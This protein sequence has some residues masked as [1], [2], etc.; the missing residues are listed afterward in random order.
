MGHD[1]SG[2]RALGPLLAGGPAP[3]VYI[4]SGP[5]LLPAWF[6]RALAP[7]LGAGTGLWWIDACNDFDVHGLS[8]AARALGFDPRS[9]LRR[10][11]L[12]RAFNL[13]QLESIV[14]GKLPAVWNGEPVVLCDPSPMIGD[15]EIPDGDRRRVG[16]SII[17][18]MR[19]L[20]AVWLVLAV[21]RGAGRDWWFE[22]LSARA[23]A[24]VRLG[25]GGGGWEL[26]KA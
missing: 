18:G 20:P 8:R 4:A 24:A 13:F 1:L 16:Q 26:A 19:G 10:L 6:L 22:S 14:R 11:R 25:A 12:A 15:P 9:V 17:E 3:G 23:E 21:D 7:A 5:R 2:C